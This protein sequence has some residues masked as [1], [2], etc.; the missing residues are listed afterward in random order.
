MGERD[1]QERQAIGEM[2]HGDSG[3]VKS[4]VMERQDRGEMGK[5]E[6]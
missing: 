5:G 6:V 1:G 4:P 2:G 3:E